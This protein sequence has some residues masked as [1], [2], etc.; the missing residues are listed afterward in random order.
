[1]TNNRPVEIG[2]DSAAT[3]YRISKEIESNTLALM[4]GLAPVPTTVED[5]D[6]TVRAIAEMLPD[7]LVM[8]GE[9]SVKVDRLSDDIGNVNKNTLDAGKIAGEARAYSLS[10]YEAVDDA[11][12]E[13]AAFTAWLRERLDNFSGTTIL[14]RLDQTHSAT[15]ELLDS[16]KS[17]HTLVE[18]MLAEIAPLKERIE[19]S[20]LLKMLGVKSND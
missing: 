6:K 11:N 13:R 1:M 16:H 17:I 14:A 18:N 4:D 8:I 9:I 20:P 15:S 2:T 10:V 19:K 7:M 3:L 5:T 12:T